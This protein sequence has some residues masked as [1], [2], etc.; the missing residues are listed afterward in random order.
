MEEDLIKSQIKGREIIYYLTSEDDLNNLRQKGTL[1]D[2]FIL[3]F[4]LAAGGI[5][6]LIITKTLSVSL[7]SDVIKVIEVLAIVF[8]VI[9]IIFLCLSV[10]F[11]CSSY[12]TISKIMGSGEIK[13]FSSPNTK[14]PIGF[15]IIEA[16]YWTPKVHKDITQKLIG[17]IKNNKLEVIASNEIDGDPDVGTRKKLTIK[18]RHNGMDLIKEYN[19][20]EKIELP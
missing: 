16:K 6:S 1:A 5:I 9:A 20:K 3:L 17:M 19:E 12:K 11:Y 14:K 4:S 7:T 10:Y 13:S 2:L 8:I 18:Y 15:E